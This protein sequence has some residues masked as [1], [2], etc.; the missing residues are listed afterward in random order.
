M[1]TTA[2]TDPAAWLRG[3][4]GRGSVHTVRLSFS[5]HLGAWRGKRIP[6][7]HFLDQHLEG[8][9][10]FC[11]GMIV[12]D[13]QCDII[14]ETPYSNFETGYPDFHVWADLPRMRLAAWAPG[15]A[16]VFGDPADHH[17]APFDVAPRQV[18]RR[19]IEKLGALGL[20]AT[21]SVRVGGR[22]MADPE[23]GVEMGRGGL[24]PLENLGPVDRAFLGVLGAGYPVASLQAGASPGE[25]TIG[26][27]PGDPFELAEAIVVTKGA[28]KELATAEGMTSTFMTRTR[29][30]S[31]P[32][33]L[34][35]VVDTDAEV[36]GGSLAGRVYEARGVLQPSVT[37]L[38]AGVP[39]V[40]LVGSEEGG[41]T[42]VGTFAASA[43]ADPF[44][45]IAVALA[46]V[47][48]DVMGTP[49]QVRTV[50]PRDLIEAAQILGDSSWAR[51]W[52]SD[53]Y[54][55]NAV[56][57]LLHEASLIDDAVTDWELD[58]YW[59]SA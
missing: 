48:G 14:Q 5:D 55:D 10:G 25:F 1:T 12:C 56:P 47:G 9:M 26:V 53:A 3:E 13:V 34:E 46:A 23:M 51:E 37:S 33:Q 54:V 52:L 30:G 42:R 41:R 15:E 38:K 44:A 24:A 21:V 57:L 19:A 43:E 45:A 18:L 39:P 6:A 35:I 59:S 22:L 36:P 11:D 16:F 49:A 8:P 58:R 29:G 32:S 28:C 40:P 20:A 27:G 2:G 50:P 7:Q 17:G 4:I 31:R